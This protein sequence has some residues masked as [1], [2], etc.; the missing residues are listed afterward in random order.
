MSMA[1]TTSEPMVVM[2]RRIQSMGTSMAD[3]WG[4]R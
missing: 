2:L 1:R 3:E 4:L